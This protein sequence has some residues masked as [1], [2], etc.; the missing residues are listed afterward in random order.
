[1]GFVNTVT[2]DGR[3]SR[4]DDHRTQRHDQMCRVV[5]RA[6]HDQGADLSMDEMA[7]ALGTSKSIIYRYFGDKAGLQDAVGAQILADFASS[8]AEAA[9]QGAEPRAQV[10]QMVRL[11]L[12]MLAKSPNV[13]YFITRGEH[14]PSA[15]PGF[16][17]QVVD[18]VAGIMG[19]GAESESTRI[20]AAGVV[21]L[22]RGAGEE[23]LNTGRK[24]SVEAMAEQMTTWIW[25]GVT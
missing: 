13:Y 7:T 15:F 12:V 11:Y 25:A 5:R 16:L 9:R 6:V 14:E 18:L 20:W 21:G 24:F 17:A 8:L 2:L 23:W 22:V 3:S 4:W 19:T 1:M 10:S